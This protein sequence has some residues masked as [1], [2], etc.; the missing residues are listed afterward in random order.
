[1]RIAANI[2]KMPELARKRINLSALSRPTATATDSPASP[3]KSWANQTLISGARL[4][5]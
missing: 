3:Q 1:M 4:L 2:A 5:Y